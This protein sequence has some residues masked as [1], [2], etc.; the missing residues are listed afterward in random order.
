MDLFQIRLFFFSQSVIHLIL[1]ILNTMK[2]YKYSSRTILCARE[3]EIEEVLDNEI[4]K[5]KPKD[6]IS[7]NI[8]PYINPSMTN[9]FC[10]PVCWYVSYIYRWKI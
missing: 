3:E 5:F 6:V 7:I 4:S 10:V 8:T 2:K 1:E 9:G